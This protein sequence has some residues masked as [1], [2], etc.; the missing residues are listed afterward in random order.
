M[1]KSDIKYYIRRVI[2]A[3]LVALAFFLIKSCNVNA[4]CATITPG[5]GYYYNGSWNTQNMNPRTVP[6]GVNRVA[7]NFANSDI[8]NQ[9]FIFQT[10]I[11]F[12][13]PGYNGYQ[14]LNPIVKYSYS[15]ASLDI[16]NACSIGVQ[17]INKSPVDGLITYRYWYTIQCD[18]Q[19]TQ[20]T[21]YRLEINFSLPIPA[22]T[23]NSYATTMFFDSA[24]TCLT[25]SPSS[26]DLI[27]NNNTQNSINI[28]NA[29]NENGQQQHQD[30]Q[31]INNTMNNSN[32]DTNNATST[33]SGISLP[34]SNVLGNLITMPVQ[35]VQKFINALS[36][37]TCT[38]YSLGTLFGTNFTLPCV[39]LST[40][41]GAVWT[42]LDVVVSG[43]IAYEIGKH[44]VLIFHKLTSFDSGTLE[45]VYK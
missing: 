45:E 22:Y 32:V 31:D 34:S 37:N 17:T 39:D 2:G 44:F 13:L 43:F 4:A 9:H 14:N 20:T 10:K 36:T 15:G 28:E 24:V 35:L 19:G 41:L 30:L 11:G 8:K 1:T 27:I 42:I 23:Q 21:G 40:I 7:L 25:F 6:N 26:T 5:L 38:P 16:S 12:D 3:L 29:I 33:I 18:Y